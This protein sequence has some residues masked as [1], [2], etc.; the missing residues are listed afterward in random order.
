MTIRTSL[1]A[2]AG[3]TA[4]VLVGTAGAAEAKPGKRNTGAES[5]AALRAEVEELRSEVAAL[6]ARIDAQDVTQRQATAD[7]QAAQQAAQAAAAQAQAAQT[8][9]AAA[10]AAV[11]G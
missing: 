8:Q 9:V 2:G 5:N 3:L 6:T 10:A 7:A 11:P 4:L 1:L